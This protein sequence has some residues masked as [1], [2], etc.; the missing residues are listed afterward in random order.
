V[1]RMRPDSIWPELSASARAGEVARRWESL[2]DKAP[3]L[4][5]WVDQ[6]LGRQRMH[7]QQSG[8]AQLEVERSLWQDLSRWLADFE[9]LP[10]FA[11]S[12]IAVT[13]EDETVHQVDPAPPDATDAPADASPERAVA[14]LE[15]L[16]SDPAFALAYHCVDARLRP[17]LSAAHPELA[18]VTES[19]WFAL[20]HAASK[21]RPALNAEVAIALVLHVLSA[22]WASVP[23]ASR[24]AALRLFLARPEDLRGDVRALCGALPARWA[25]GPV[26]M[27]LFVAAAQDARVAVGE[28]ARLC[29]RLVAGAGDRPGSLSLLADGATVPPSPE[30][31]AE[32]FRNFRKYKHLEGF[33]R[34]MT[35]L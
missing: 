17:R 32:L 2:L 11:V 19:D 12:A 33:R 21:P 6:M 20:L 10:Q 13:L 16:L 24:H 18:A 4:R 35:L 5:P 8:I 9:A 34:L 28:A 1:R 26:Q 14:D 3:R 27:P 7:L 25:L 31:V 30:E 29:A 22:G 15:A 23:T